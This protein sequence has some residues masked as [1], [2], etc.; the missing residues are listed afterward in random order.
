MPPES[1]AAAAASAEASTGDREHP[2]ASERSKAKKIFMSAISDLSDRFGDA[3]S[4]VNRYAGR[5]ASLALL[6]Y[7]AVQIGKKK[8]VDAVSVIALGVGVVLWVKSSPPP[9][10]FTKLELGSLGQ[11]L[12][13][14]AESGAVGL[15][16]QF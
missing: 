11:D 4:S 15:G 3:L 14:S 1:A 6:V 9:A 10:S 13:A 2:T 5:A 8:Q 12:G 16:G 7:G